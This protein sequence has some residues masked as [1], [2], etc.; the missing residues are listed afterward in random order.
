MKK[1]WGG[2]ISERDDEN[3][4]R[5]GRRSGNLYLR[6][7]YDERVPAESS[8]EKMKKILALLTKIRFLVYLRE[9]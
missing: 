2:T 4:F 8:G 1:K 3:Y 7:E 5:T 6:H 9:L